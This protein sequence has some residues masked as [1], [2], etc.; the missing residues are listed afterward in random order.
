[1]LE[2]LRTLKAELLGVYVQKRDYP[3]TRTFIGKGKLEEF[4]PTI[5][6]AK[7]DFVV[8][9]GPIKPPVR[10]N[11]EKEFQ[12]EVYDRTRVI[13]E[14][15][16]QRASS[17][18]AKLQVELAELHY[19]IPMYREIMHR[20]TVGEHP[21]YMAGGETQVRYYY[22]QSTKHQRA[23]R[24][25]LAA[26]E[27]SREKK[28]EHRQREGFITASI[29]GYTNA[30]KS[31]LLNALTGESVLVDDMMFATLS[32]T[33]RRF[34]EGQPKLLLTDTVG[35]IEDLPPW[36]I[37]AFNSTMEEV[38]LSDIVILVI[39]AS[40]RTFLMTNKVRTCQDIIRRSLRNQ[41][42]I[43]VLNKSDLVSSAELL[44]KLEALKPELGSLVPLVLSAKQGKGLEE[45]KQRIFAV[46][47]SVRETALMRITLPD[48][49]FTPTFLSWL[50]KNTVIKEKKIE[51]GATVIDAL[52]PTRLLKEM[53]QKAKATGC[54]V[55]GPV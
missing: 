40:D 24:E 39:D 21:G 31:S 7:P 2:L 37:E 22:T 30:G 20:A 10:F 55:E 50:Y 41:T 26:L 6:A 44:E 51:E 23:I 17:E 47:E 19:Q 52:V 14:I 45:L 43:P 27:G 1:M 13:L 54:K 48:D 3:D 42:I 49:D 33:T 15:F 53:G 29:T 34:G 32:T 46:Q 5:L 38:F 16:K 9:N 18:E 8:V 36:M 28:R 11:L 4:K 25:R 12:L 35:F